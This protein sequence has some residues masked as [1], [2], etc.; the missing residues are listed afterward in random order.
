MNN[1]IA[2]KELAT[3]L[4]I[5]VKALRIRVSKGKIAQPVKREGGELFWDREAVGVRRS[6]VIDDDVSH[7]YLT[8]IKPIKFSNVD[9]QLMIER[10]SI[11]KEEAAR[12]REHGTFS[13]TESDV[14]IGIQPES[15]ARRGELQMTMVKSRADKSQVESVS[16]TLM[17]S[18]K[19]RKPFTAKDGKA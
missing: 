8:D 5:S 4:N 1:L 9:L 13:L 14:F 6:V 3:Y 15:G 17:F 11:S 2:T 16:P 7:A 12:Y 19:H 18:S 10:G